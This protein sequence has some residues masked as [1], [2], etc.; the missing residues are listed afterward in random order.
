MRGEIVKGLQL[1]SLTYIH[2]YAKFKITNAKKKK[3]I[4]MPRQR[5]DGNNFPLPIFLLLFLPETFALNI[6]PRFAIFFAAQR[7][8]SWIGIQM[9]KFWGGLLIP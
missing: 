9:K 5:G 8:V 6:I 3:S 7:R 2:T 4:F 1:A